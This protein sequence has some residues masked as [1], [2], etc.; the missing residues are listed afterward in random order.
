M[1]EK[2]G[3][4]KEKGLEGREGERRMGNRERRGK[5]RPIRNRLVLLK[6]KCFFYVVPGLVYKNRVIKDKR[7]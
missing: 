1:Q 5:R 7:K 2:E 6:K 3:K 4:G